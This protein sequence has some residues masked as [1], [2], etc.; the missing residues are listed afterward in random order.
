MQ[1]VNGVTVHFHSRVLM[2]QGGVF[3]PSERLEFQLFEG[4]QVDETFLEC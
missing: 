2:Q 3:D 1:K 4:V